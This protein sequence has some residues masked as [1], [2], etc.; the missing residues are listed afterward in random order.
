M[1]W[2]GSAAAKGLSKI[3]QTD[4][5]HSRIDAAGMCIWYVEVKYNYLSN[6]KDM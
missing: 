4:K 6:K 2:T 5:Y 3:L 1:D